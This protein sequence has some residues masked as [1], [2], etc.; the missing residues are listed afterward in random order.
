MKTGKRLFALLLAMTLCLTMLP[1]SAAAAAASIDLA[2][3]DVE[4]PAATVGQDYGPV[5]LTV[6]GKYND[7]QW[8]GSTYY[9]PSGISMTEGG[10]ISGTCT[11]TGA[12]SGG[13]GGGVTRTFTVTATPRDPEAGLAP[14]TR[15]L[16]ITYY[17]D[18]PYRIYLNPNGAWDASGKLYSS[19]EVFVM[20]GG[21][22]DL[23][24]YRDL[25]PEY[26]C[27]VQTGWRTSQSDAA[28]SV[29][30]G[31]TAQYPVT[32]QEILW[33]TW[34][35][36]TYTISYDMDGGVGAEDWDYTPYTHTTTGNTPLHLGTA[37]TREGYTFL[38]WSEDGGEHLRTA[39]AYYYLRELN[40]SN[41]QVDYEAP[42]ATAEIVFK[43]QWLKDDPNAVL[44]VEGEPKVSLALARDG[45]TLAAKGRYDVTLI[46]NRTVKSGESA[47]A[48][49]NYTDNTGAA[50]TAALS[51]RLS[52]NR[53]TENGTLPADAKRVEGLTFTLNGASQAAASYAIQKDV[54][55]T[56]KV[57]VN[58]TIYAGQLRLTS[59]DAD[60][61]VSL[62]GKTAEITDLAPG[63]YEA[64]L[65]GWISGYGTTELARSSVTLTGGE[66]ATLTL[67]AAS[68]KA[69]SVTATAKNAAGKTVSA[70]Y[71]WYD[72]NTA[73]RKTLATG[74]TYTFLGGETVYV[75]A[76]PTGNDSVYY[77]ASALV[78][79]NS[80]SA[81]TV[82]L[83]VL[84]KD[85][86]GATVTAV[87][88]DRNGEGTESG[89]VSITASRPGT[90]GAAASTTKIVNGGEAAIFEDITEGTVITAGAA[91]SAAYDTASHTVTAA[92]IEAG[93]LTVSLTVPLATNAI[94]VTVLRTNSGRTYTSSLGSLDSYLLKKE[95]DTIVAVRRAN[96]ALVL[97]D[98]DQVKPGDKLTLEGRVNGYKDQEDFPRAKGSVT[99]QFGEPCTL[100]LAER[101]VIQVV[102]T[103]TALYPFAG[104]LY[105]GSGELIWQD[106]NA[107]NNNTN[108][109]GAFN[110]PYLVP[111]SY[112]VALVNRSF[113]D[114]LE[115]EAYDTLDEA[116]K[117]EHSTFAAGQNVNSNWVSW[118][119]SLPGEDPGHGRVNQEASGVTMSREYTGYITLDL[120]VTPTSDFDPTGTVTVTV[121]TN[122]TWNGSGHV[123]SSR[124]LT[125]NGH[126]V[127]LKYAGG[128]DNGNLKSNGLLSVALTP[129]QLREVGGFPLTLQA[130]FVEQNLEA[131]S[132]KAYLRYTQDGSQNCDF[133][134]EFYAQTGGLTLE[135]PDTVADGQFTVYGKG[136]ASLSGNP[137][138]VTI[139]ADGAPVATAKTDT[140]RGWYK[141]KLDLRGL[142]PGEIRFTAAGSY[143]KDV[144][145]SRQARTATAEECVYDPKGGALVKWEILNESKKGSGQMAPLTMIDD[146]DPVSLYKN[147]G[148]SIMYGD[149]AGTQ[150]RMTFDNPDQILGVQVFVR[151]SEV[152]TIQAEKQPDGTWLTPLTYFPGL[153]PDDATVEYT[154]KTTEDTLETLEKP[155]QTA[156]KRAY[157]RLNSTDLVRNLTVR[158]KDVSL[159]LKSEKNTWL[160]LTLRETELP[161]NATEA[162]QLAALKPYYEY[163]TDLGDAFPNVIWHQ[164]GL[165]LGSTE[166][167]FEGDRWVLGAQTVE[168]LTDEAGK[169]Y[170][171][172]TTATM[173]RRV[174][175]LY[176]V[177]AQTKTLVSLTL[178]DGT[179][180]NPAPDAELAAKAYALEAEENAEYAVNAERILTIYESWAAVYQQLGA[181]LAQSAADEISGKK[182]TAPATVT[183]GEKASLQAVVSGSLQNWEEFYKKSKETIERLEEAKETGEDLA[184][185]MTE[186]EVN[187]D[188][189]HKM[190]RFLK[191]NPCLSL[192]YRFNKSNGNVGP[193]DVVPEIKELYWTTMLEKVNGA[194]DT[195]TSF[196]KSFS[197]KGLGAAW[198]FVKDKF[199]EYPEA[200]LK[201]SCRSAVFG[202]KS[203][204]VAQRLYYAA[205]YAETYEKGGWGKLCNEGIDWK[206]FPKDLYE[207]KD[208]EHTKNLLQLYQVHINAPLPVNMKKAPT[209]PRGKYDPSGYVYEAVPS[210]RV[211]GATVSLYEF[212]NG[213]AVLVDADLFGL[214]PNP[215]TTGADGRYQWFVPEGW[216]RVKVS[217]E[218]YE[219]ADTGSSAEYGLDAARQS[220]GA[221]YMP[222]LPVQLDVNIPLVDYT[223]PV[224]QEVNATT[225]GI[226]VTFSKYMEEE[227]LTPESVTLTVN[228]EERQVLGVVGADSEAGVK[229]D[230]AAAALS[231]I[232]RV[233]YEE[234]AENDK[235][236][237]ALRAGAKSYAGTPMAEDH[238]TEELTVKAPAPAEKPTASVAAGAVEKNTAVALSSATP[239]AVLYYTLDGT[240]PTTESPRYREPVIIDKA[241]TLKAV[242]VKPGMET[243]EVL[244]AA[245][246]VEEAAKIVPEKVTASIRGEAVKDGDTLEPGM[247]LLSTATPGAEIWYTTNGVCPK[248]DP[249]PILY[250]GPIE[251]TEG[252]WFFRIR[253]RL[254]GVWSDGLPL[255]LTVAGP[256]KTT[257][258]DVREKDWFYSAVYYCAERG[259]FT[260]VSDTT[261]E[262][263][264]TM[265]RAMF[266]TVLY[267]IAGKPEVTGKSPFTD[268]PDGKWYSD[269]II[270][271]AGKEILTGYGN[272]KF[273]LD[274]AVT[275]EQMV[276]IFWR[277]Q[278]KPAGD[279]AAL[280][281]FTD[282]GKIS[283]YARE[284]FAWAVSAGVISGKGNGIL[285]PKGT[286]KRSEVAQIVMNYGTKVG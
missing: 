147:Y 98:P 18:S 80:A 248:D 244:T 59:A 146:G 16:T 19:T 119:V 217:K 112:T 123:D 8:T 170:Y 142:E 212:T 5:Q 60:V 163:G 3:G 43:A 193:F 162:A 213:S 238:T 74:K 87:L 215:Q 282:A 54:A 153:A 273:G 24:P 144:E 256:K 38:G 99:F 275:R 190:H 141:A 263:N 139:Y 257:F 45:E 23:T 225:E 242:A 243:S 249:D 56:L 278:G 218:G 176:D 121:N 274:D 10:L 72:G 105:N 50:K 41:L 253:A 135:A 235:V 13:T 168:K 214:E 222:V 57:T 171:L 130:V 81:S 195:A 270:W 108:S 104:L 201:E 83:P 4:L 120:R 169:V 277:Y 158:G 181:A 202:R 125:V 154:T 260:G 93:G 82:S 209:E 127:L 118:R 145:G 76:F 259:Y 252:T 48:T 25:F 39:R 84:Q 102:W 180:T 136:P 221:W 20:G 49:V 77:Q 247:L 284:A 177:A 174:T 232:F 55:P 279:E 51:L 110:T 155:G 67:G 192:L 69:K 167:G 182:I 189:A 149:E 205:R 271:A 234:P 264:S 156:L 63:S 103:R 106:R 70:D 175:V 33:A 44:K 268:V 208:D 114:T 237:L 283:S 226:Y 101:G 199:S 228:G 236:V 230:G 126:P 272:G 46:L 166:D 58:G 22:L 122:Q 206:N 197:E 128:L 88:T 117:L 183:A 207:P 204:K 137:Y 198:D 159:E 12:G 219:T 179:P 68:P 92:E 29:N 227:S 6:D 233:S 152:V 32:G 172:S 134:G 220:D 143:Q 116:K 47:R 185:W 151:R 223:A 100:T 36:I 21:T 107:I 255:H 79:V 11:A 262:P 30:V 245:Y 40:A 157:D 42:A 7:Y 52:G 138:T 229:A 124:S 71:L 266:A 129:Q 15:T 113:F 211:E 34:T 109:S 200:K 265:T 64:V 97:L 14:V 241:L 53:A 184:E 148:R 61:T 281:S 216:W 1:L 27:Y 86:T 240:E 267:R 37:P 131:M 254:D 115:P 231:S 96:D 251:L 111:D 140:N 89:R 9:L 73:D 165:F 35:P 269:P 224:V 187:A 258:V 194:L 210:N 95:D 250:T 239:G 160:P 178:G 94:P 26:P 191:D 132:A 164:E 75:Q 261:F 203:T 285:D 90:S 246:T 65:S 280:S 91:N 62:S 17:S 133:I 196:G 31:L 186:V 28:G 150:W 286:A 66:T 161:W 85:G 173:A 276:T 2:E 78:A 188:E